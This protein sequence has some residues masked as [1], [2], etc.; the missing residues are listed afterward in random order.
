MFPRRIHPCSGN[1]ILSPPRSG[2][3]LVCAVLALALGLIAAPPSARANPSARPAA[4]SPP[5][6]PAAAETSAPGPA[7]G[8]GITEDELKQMLLGKRLYLRGGYLGDSLNFN[9]HGALVDHSP[10]GSYTLCGVVITKVRLSKHKVQLKGIRYGVHF[11]SA[12]PSEDL[13]N[14]VDWVRIT[15][16]KKVLKITI[17]RERVVKPKKIKHKRSRHASKLPAPAPVPP[18]SSQAESADGVTTSP[19]HAAMALRQ[20]LN[21]VF[22]Q[23]IDARMIAAMPRFWRLYYQP[24]AAHGKFRP[25]DPAVQRQ[26]AVDRKAKLLSITGPGSNQYAQTSD[27][28]GL[29]LYHVVVGP[30]GKAQEIA[31]ARPIGFGLD[32]N[33]VAAIRKARFEPALKNGK[34]VPVVLNLVV[35]FRI[36]SK[37]TS[38]PAPPGAANKP[39]QPTL[40]GPY[41]V[42]DRH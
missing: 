7:R 25:T 8:R 36:Y 32:A 38:K 35:E 3:W 24:A 9:V 27:V 39:S 13:S 17:A 29:A 14:A 26:D 40:P 20:A 30:D 41:S 5:P 21:N 16:K 10:Q 4:Q 19:A 18:P 15:P 23:S 34:P 22:A 2:A 6:L 37:L 28:A 11:L 42:E 31:V 1:T 33:A 12:L